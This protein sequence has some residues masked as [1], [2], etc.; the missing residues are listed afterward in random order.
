MKYDP[1]TR[2]F[3]C[4]PT[5]NDSQVVD[6]CREGHTLL[7]GVVPDDINQRTCKYLE[8]R[9]PANPSWIPEGM[10]N[11]DLERIRTSHAPSTILLEDWFLEHVLLNP[12]VSG[13]IRSLLGRNVGLPVLVSDHRC[14]CPQEA[15]RWHHDADHVF[16]PELNFVE[17][18]YFPQDTPADLG[19]SEIAPSTHI[20]DTRDNPPESG[21]L[22]EGPAGT[23]GIHHQSILHRRGR[24][25][26]TGTRHMLK[27]SYWRTVPP[28]RDWILDPGFDPH[29]ADYGGHNVA[30]YVAHIHYWLC[31]KTDEVRLIGGQGWPKRNDNDIAP[32]YGFGASEGYQP[33]WR[34]KSPDGYAR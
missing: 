22:S 17:V 5:L 6:F 33:A 18:F 24:S 3:D 23:V 29:T 16:G 21:V 27:Y 20:R 10:T 13:A 2:T 14:E 9:L 15:Q 25:T 30:R 32:R 34:S 7:H 28:E 31:G 4:E 19:P 26:R 11:E 12:K 8:G 1:Q